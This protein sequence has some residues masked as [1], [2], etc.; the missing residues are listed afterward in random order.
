M[1][2]KSWLIFSFLFVCLAVVAIVLFLPNFKAYTIY[3]LDPATGVSYKIKAKHGTKFKDYLKPDSEDFKGYYLDSKF[4]IKLNLEDYISQNLS[5]TEANIMFSDVQN[6]NK[7]VY[8]LKLEGN[9]STDDLNFLCNNFKYLDLSAADIDG[10]FP[11]VNTF[12]NT[13]ILNG[14]YSINNFTN[15]KDVYNYSQD[16]TD[17]FNNC[18]NLSCVYLNNIVSINNCFNNCSILTEIEL[19][20][21]S[22][23]SHSFI[24]TQ[25]QKINIKS[26][27][28]FV[29]EDVLYKKSD[30][31]KGKILVKALS[32]LKDINLVNTYKIEDYAFSGIKNSFSLSCKDEILTTIGNNAFSLSNI[33]KA[34]FN[35]N[36]VI[37]EM[38]FYNCQQLK[39]IS[40]N[41]IVNF[42]E[43]SFMQSGIESLDLSSCSATI[44]NYSFAD[45]KN[46]KN[47]RLSDNLI[48]L[49]KGAFSGC[50]S[51]AKVVNLHTEIISEYC[52][53]D[54]VNLSDISEIKELITIQNYAFKNTN[55]YNLN[56][57]SGVV[58]IKIGAFESCKNLQSVKLFNLQQ[59][60][61]NVFKNCTN[62]TEFYNFGNLIVFENAF[63]NCPINTINVLGDCITQI[64]SAIYNKDVTELL[65][66]VKN[67]NVTFYEIPKTI[68]KI[69][70]QTLS[71]ALNL[72]N[73]SVESGGNYYSQDGILYSKDKTT[74][75]CYPSAKQQ[76]EFTFPNFVTTIAKNAFYSC[77]NL[78]KITILQ[79]IITIQDGCFVNMQNLQ[80][81]ST[82]FLGNNLYDYNTGYLG[83]MFGAKESMSTGYYVPSSLKEVTVTNQ[84]NFPANA[85]YECLNL[86]KIVLKNTDIISKNMFY[87]CVNLKSI[88][89][90]KPLLK[91]NSLAFYNT[92]KL[93]NL[94]LVYNKNLNISFNALVN[95]G[96][97]VTV[98]LHNTQNLT[99]TEYNIY[100]SKFG[101]QTWIW[102]IVKD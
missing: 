22:Q 99:N 65:Y 37:G 86:Q 67:S 96:K 51:L 1:N 44:N 4:N 43:K 101:Q 66:Y 81:L 49:G 72:Q 38:A 100:K 77:P 85:F 48:N 50:T 8:G 54:C 12:V 97:N 23:I 27:N 9:L 61:A 7:N 5:L 92:A 64:G 21:V 89:I 68:D 30:D 6:I 95:C 102:K 41:G 62:L 39:N 19:N 20:N 82:P 24:N 90:E 53:S 3:V 11:I 80:I 35:G 59:L 60:H 55:L 76:G 69:N 56:S 63:L 29:E 34:N 10:K 33:T 13:L 57:V 15:L 45:C 75:L 25:I 52:F 94:S 84:D 40:F 36:L 26:A 78:L 2:K 14:N 58:N 87:N 71:N 70:T 83:F 74:L 42:Q 18:P 88:I 16:I 31:N 98:L 93:N 73:I 28:Y 46:L 17:T 91:I 32:N 47:V 79:N